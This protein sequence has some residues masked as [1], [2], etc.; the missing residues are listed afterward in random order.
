[1]PNKVLI[2]ESDPTFA[3][4]LRAGFVG[5]GCE[6]SVVD[7]ANVGLQ[8][9]TESKPDLILLAIELPRTNGFSV[10]NKLKRDKALAGVPLIILSSSSTDETF[11]QHRRL[12]T[13]AEDYIHKPVS[14]DALLDHV[15]Q[16]VRLE[17]APSPAGDAEPASVAIEAVEEDDLVIDEVEVS[18]PV[19]DVAPASVSPPMGEDVEDA[20]EAALAESLAPDAPALSEPPIA[21]E[22]MRPE[23][24]VEEVIDDD[25]I[26]LESAPTSTDPSLESAPNPAVS[27]ASRPPTF[28][29]SS[30]PPRPND[31]AD[32]SRFRDEIERQKARV[33]ELEESARAAHA[34]AAEFEDALRRGAAR[35]AEVQR[36]QRDLD[37]A[38]AK[39]SSG[40]PN[41][42]GGSAREFL[43]LR[44][45]MNKKDKEILELRDQV[46]H[47]D[48]DLLA[49]KDGSLSIERD[50]ADL[51]DRVAE[52]EQ[53]LTEAQKRV[54]AAKEDKEQA[55]KRADDFKRKFE[56]QKTDLDERNEEIAALRAVHEGELAERE[57]REAALRNDI[58]EAKRRGEAE[59]EGAVS[60]TEEQAKTRL[61]EALAS[62][63]VAA[64]AELSSAVEQARIATK[65]ELEAETEARLAAHRRAE[66]ETIGK[67]RAEQSQ[68][69]READESATQRLAEQKAAIERELGG[70]LEVTTRE[71][72]QK[73]E[74]LARTEA[75]VSES[76]NRV[77]ALEAELGAAREGLARQEQ[78][79]SIAQSR[80]THLG[81]ELE[82]TNNELDSFRESAAQ[83]SEANAKL[84]AEVRAIRAELETTKQA[85]GEERGTLE[86]ARTT[87]RDGNTALE[88][89]KDALAAALSQVEE[90]QRR[91]PA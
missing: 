27:R 46:T 45:Q 30:L 85:L 38:K 37:E 79:L 16:F 29:P 35:D 32:L 69:L 84:E 61:E 54:D 26:D 60:A 65:Q 6:V 73:A 75:L 82:A 19:D 63:A 5:L 87:W 24:V 23:P 76:A 9:A 83:R 28:T 51:V 44:E 4:A 20:V 21:I 1:M 56:K 7:D 81:N 17:G 86:R 90:A 13:R 80:V 12:R 31:S 68:A 39:I 59:L 40:A 48:K 8:A 50:K 34:K 78:D 11:D 22:S 36:L 58:E 14:F 55:S 25:E 62:A 57:A 72:E 77:A 33:R 43:D 89:A 91:G 74:A 3:D 10:C 18:E 64:A 52:L 53:K 49:L 2:F 41:K 47:R 71:L 15:Q 67:L 70:R 42:G 88:R 66:E